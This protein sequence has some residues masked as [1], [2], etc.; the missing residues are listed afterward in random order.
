MALRR[1]H[2]DLATGF[3][4]VGL[5][6]CEGAKPT[7]N[8]FASPMVSQGLC[9]SARGR[10]KG[11]ARGSVTVRFYRE[12]VAIGPAVSSRA[13]IDLGVGDVGVG[14]CTS[15]GAGWDDHAVTAGQRHVSLMLSL[16]VRAGPVPV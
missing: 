13:H 16:R 6:R 8:C 2:R 9:L 1:L 10:S 7:W 4:H 15:F 14:D 12:A 11:S 5:T 3:R